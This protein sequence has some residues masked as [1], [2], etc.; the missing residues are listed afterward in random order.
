MFEWR[1]FLVSCSIPFSATHHDDADTSSVVPLQRVSSAP[2][3]ASKLPQRS[4]CDPGNPG[5]TNCT[6]WPAVMRTCCFLPGHCQLLNNDVFCSDTHTRKVVKRAWWQFSFC[7][8][9][10]RLEWKLV[11]GIKRWSLFD[12]N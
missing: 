2:S 4:C 10:C 7:E 3:S 6:M 12:G 8:N 1:S 9:Q 5:T 11:T